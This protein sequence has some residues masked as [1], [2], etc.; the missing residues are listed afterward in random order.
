MS[1]EKVII[2]KNKTRLEQLVERFNTKDQAKFYI[3]HSVGGS[4]KDYE[5]EHRTF[6]NA[7]DKLNNMCDQKLKVHLIEK[8]FLPNYI[9]PKSSFIITLGQDGLVAN[10]AKYSKDIPIVGVNPDND[11][12]DGILLPFEMSSFKSSLENIIHGD[13]DS[14]NVTMAKA[15]L[16]NGQELIAF[17]DLF[18]GPSNHTSARYSVEYNDKIEQQS[19]SGIIISTG[20]GSTGW[21][22]SLINMSSGI[23]TF[24]SRKKTSNQNTYH[25]PWD[26]KKLI[27][28]VREPFKSKTSNIDL[29]MGEINKST[30]FKLISHM[31]FNGIIFSDGVVSDYLDFNSG[32][33]L[34][35]GLAEQSATLITG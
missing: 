5:D 15:K 26:S 33:V 14:I 21:L 35:I 4:F 11:R 23:N 3:E 19:S 9:F 24:L 2:I 31:P 17:N 16:N 32:S 25:L 28:V 12:Y 10:T 20:A 22:S 1:F 27:F 29:V 13:F 6:Y 18:I 8:S 30:E 34:T 7:L